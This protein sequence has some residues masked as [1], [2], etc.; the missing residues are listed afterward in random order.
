MIVDFHTVTNNKG[1]LRVAAPCCRRLV[2]VNIFSVRA[3]EH[4]LVKLG[5]PSI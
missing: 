1:M 4:S 3:S 5:Q 2:A